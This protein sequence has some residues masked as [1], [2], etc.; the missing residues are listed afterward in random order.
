MKTYRK[1]ENNYKK[2]QNQENKLQRN[3]KNNDKQ[4]KSKK[5]SKGFNYKNRSKMNKRELDNNNIRN[6][7]S[8]KDKRR[9]G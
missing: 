5:R 7:S 4:R 9:N 1:E 2:K 3:S 6:L 8:R